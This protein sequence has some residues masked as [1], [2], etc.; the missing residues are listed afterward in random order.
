MAGIADRLRQRRGEYFSRIAFFA[1][2]EQLCD[3]AQMP[4]FVIE[5]AF[6]HLLEARIDFSDEIRKGNMAAATVIGAFIIGVCFI[7][8]ALFLPETKN[9]DIS[10]GESSVE[11]GQ[12]PAT[13]PAK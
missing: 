8:G 4:Q 6:P 10:A 5:D 12:M 7:I 11:A 3:E 9:I 2:L 13:A 1:I